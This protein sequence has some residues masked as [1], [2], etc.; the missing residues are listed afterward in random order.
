[1]AGY[2]PKS[3]YSVVHVFAGGDA[4]GDRVLVLDEAD[5]ADAEEELCAAAEKEGETGV[6]GAPG[7]ASSSSSSSTSST[8]SS[9]SS[10]SSSAGG[11]SGGVSGGDGASVVGS[12]SRFDVAVLLYDVSSAASFAHAVEVYRRLSKAVPCLFVGTKADLDEDEAFGEEAGDEEGG[13]GVGS[14][15]SFCEREGISAPELVSLQE[16]SSLALYSGIWHLASLPSAGNPHLKSKLCRLLGISEADASAG[17][18]SNSQTRRQ[19][20]TTKA[21]SPTTNN[22]ND[23]GSQAD[24][25]DSTSI[26]YAIAA[27]AAATAA[28]AAIWVAR[29]RA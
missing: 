4:T 8:S 7:G 21:N 6:R 22:R 25:P 11:A 20:T 10:S 12:G 16:G 23:T 18:N 9:S 3:A 27:A 17:A 24:T 13:P 14:P 29:K 19:S 1:M 28:I 15:E 5:G 26:I 2:S